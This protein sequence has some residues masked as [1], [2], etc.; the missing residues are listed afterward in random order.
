[1]SELV[2]FER[3][4][5]SLVIHLKG[6]IDSTSAPEVEKEIL[7]EVH[8]VN[9]L[10]IDCSNLEYLSSAGLRV[11]LRLKKAV[12]NL[13]ITNT[14]SSVYDIFQVTGFTEMINIRKAFRNISVK[15][16]EV[17][18]DGANGIVYRYDEETIVKVFK[19]PNA[20]PEIERE[21]DLARTAFV[22]GVPTAISYDIVRVDDSLYGSVFELLNADSYHHLLLSGEKTLDEI[23]EMSVDL[24]KIVHATVPKPGKLPSK[25]KITTEQISHIGQYLAPEVYE[26][27]VRLCSEIPENGHMLHGDFHI[28][29]ILVQNGES[30]LVDMDTLCVGDP[31][32]E[33]S[34]LYN[35][36]IGFAELDPEDPMKFF[37]LP[38]EKTSELFNKILYGYC[39]DNKEETDLLLKKIR[40]ISYARFLY[41]CAIEKHIHGDMIPI[42]VRHSVDCINEL[43]PQVEDLSSHIVY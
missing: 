34:G 41:Y 33:F 25:K 24:L 16:C 12:P 21:Q 17:I 14:S 1:M 13:V 19:N 20:L 10:E 39:G 38:K 11:I 29:N 5:D 9:S 6:R 43:L 28:K 42:A 26:K 37:G 8:D 3:S 2:S 36:Y 4:Q 15:G 23:A 31:V 18:G 40:I 32:F 35:P 7:N 27:L 22:L 30:L